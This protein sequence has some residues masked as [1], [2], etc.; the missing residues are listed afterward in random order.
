[1]RTL[2][3]AGTAQQT[4]HRGLLTG[5]GFVLVLPPLPRFGGLRLGHWYRHSAFSPA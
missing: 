4:S 2:E 5:L 1:M 3:L